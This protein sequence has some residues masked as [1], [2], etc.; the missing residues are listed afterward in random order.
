MDGTGL[1]KNWYILIY[2]IN[3]HQSWE[4]I[5]KIE[6]DLNQ[7]F[8]IKNDTDLNQGDYNFWINKTE[9]LFFKVTFSCRR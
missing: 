5:I 6:T 7:S 2:K 9:A 4:F 3:L 1:I 8:S